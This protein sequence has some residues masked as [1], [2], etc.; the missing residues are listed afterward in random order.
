MNIA[1]GGDIRAVLDTN[2]LVSAFTRP[3]GRA[4]PL[5][6]TAQAR[7]YRLLISPAI[8]REIARVLRKDFQWEE[9]RIIRRSKRLV[10]TG[11]LIIPRISLDI[12]HNDPDDNRILECAVEGKA[13]VI[14]SRDRHLRNLK[15]YQGIPIVRPI[16]FLRTLGEEIAQAT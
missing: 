13:D 8:I 14:V 9:R 7:R 4:A 16:D 5:W 12:I 2:V 10:R 1:P 11:E 6:K 15:S 3:R